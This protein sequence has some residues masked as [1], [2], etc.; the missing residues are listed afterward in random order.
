MRPSVIEEKPAPAAPP[1]V[2]E[3]K[4]RQGRAFFLIGLGVLILSGLLAVRGREPFATWFFLI[5]WWSYI[6]MVDGWVYRHRGESLL[7]GHPGRFVFLAS[8]SAVLWFVFEAFN[9]RLNN[10]SYAGLPPVTPL[11][12]AGYILAF[13]TVAPAVLETADLLESAGVAKELK[14]RGLGWKKSVEPWFVGA[15]AAM[16][17]LPLLLPKFF[18]PLVWGGFVFLLEPWNE[19]KGAASLTADWRTGRVRRFA[20]L[21]LSGF[22]CGVLWEW[23]NSISLAR[24]TYDV[25]WVGDWKVFEMPLAGYLGFPPFAVTVFVMTSTAVHVWD[26]S[27]RP[28]RALLAAA[29]LAFCLA[30]CALID[31][32]TVVSLAP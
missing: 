7:L 26:K 30:M 16:L 4:R 22:I 29:G 32:L 19:R 15:G 25:P 20:L 9:L 6:V 17:V 31:R 23:W 3:P 28:R 1:P 5:S 14:V 21:L 13:A 8:W 12:W 10:W 11:R 24:W 2:D 27:S 18:F